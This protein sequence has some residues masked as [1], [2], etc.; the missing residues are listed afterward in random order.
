MTAEFDSGRLDAYGEVLRVILDG[1][2]SLSIRGDTAEQCW[3][4]LEP[5][6]AAW[7]AGAVPLEDYQAG[8]NGPPHWRTGTD[9]GL[10]PLGDNAAALPSSTA[11]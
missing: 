7:R 6:I 9:I 8:S 4:I 10:I 5:A 3:R 1:D 2:P 11:G